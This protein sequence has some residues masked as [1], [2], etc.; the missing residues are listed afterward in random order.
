MEVA[1][2][3]LTPAVGKPGMT[4][5][6]NNPA[7][8]LTIIS[9][10]QTGVDR[11]ALDSALS[12]RVDCGGWCPEGRQAEDGPIPA[13]YPLTELGGGYAARTRKNVEDSDGTVIL[14]FDTPTG[15][16]EKTLRYCL[17]L[18][19]LTEVCIATGL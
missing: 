8:G 15:G 4:A 1:G 6:S 13:R 3:R 16:T 17:D 10:G 14:Y 18:G 12:Y 9:G 11:A 5:E 2:R 7:P 19:K